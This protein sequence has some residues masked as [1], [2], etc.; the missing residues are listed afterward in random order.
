VCCC[1]KT[2]QQQ[3]CCSIFAQGAART[4]EYSDGTGIILPATTGLREVWGRLWYPQGVWARHEGEASV[5]VHVQWR[6]A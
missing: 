2:L 6:R 5:S 3:R 1:C 4:S